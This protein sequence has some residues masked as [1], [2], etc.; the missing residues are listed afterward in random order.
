MAEGINQPR[1]IKAPCIK[2]FKSLLFQS[3]VHLFKIHLLCKAFCQHRKPSRQ[4]IFPLA[5]QE[6]LSGIQYV[7]S[8]L[9]NRRLKQIAF[10]LHSSYFLHSARSPAAVFSLHKQTEFSRLYLPETD[11]LRRSANHHMSYNSISLPGAG[12]NRYK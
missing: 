8:K 10:I 1:L 5:C 12:Y 9:C 11:P 3:F 7:H 4:R 2:A 6:S